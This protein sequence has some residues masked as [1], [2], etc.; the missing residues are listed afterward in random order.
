MFKPADL[1]VHGGAGETGP[2]LIDLLRGAYG[3]PSSLHLVNRLDKATSGLVLLAKSAAIAGQLAK[4]WEHAEKKYLAVALGRIEGERA[5]DEA[6]D[7]KYGPA[8][9]ARTWVKARAVLDAVTPMSTLIEVRLGTGRTHQIRLH[10]K[11]L[12]HPL[13]LDDKHGDFRANKAWIRAVR[14]AGGP[15]PKGLMLHARSLELD[16]PDGSGRVLLGAE[17]PESWGEILRVAGRQVDV[18][19]KLS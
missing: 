9:D 15:R 10:L 14:D 13:L 4:T 2:T 5:I 16:H 12:G 18:S 7:D 3:D 17:P 6:L 1:S 19:A 8:K 11:E